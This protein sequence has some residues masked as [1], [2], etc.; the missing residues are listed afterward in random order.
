MLQSQLLTAAPPAVARYTATD[1][2]TV[3]LP[4]LEY[5]TVFALYAKFCALVLDAVDLAAYD[6]RSGTP[7]ELVKRVSDVI[8]F[9]LARS[10]HKDKPHI[11]SLYSFLTGEGGGPQG[12]NAEG[13]GGGYRWTLIGYLD[14]YRSFES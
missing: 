3:P 11:Q 8:W 6:R 4:A 2:D 1:A 9:S 12:W 14:E 10:Y 7:R 5:D 13:R